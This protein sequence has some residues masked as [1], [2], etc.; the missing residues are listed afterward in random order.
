MSTNAIKPLPV[1]AHRLPPLPYAYDALMP[2]ISKELLT[3][4]HDKHHQ[5]YVDGLNRAEKR[6]A[7][8]RETGDYALVKHWER[9]IAFHGSGHILHSIFWTIMAPPGDRK[10]LALT[11]ELINACFGSFARFRDQFTVA[12]TD[13]EASGWAILGYQPAFSRLEIY[14]AEKHQNLTQW[15]AIPILVLDVWEHA[16][17]LD[18]LN[19]RRDWVEAWWK[20]VNW[21]E[22]ESRLKLA[23]VA[24]MPLT[25]E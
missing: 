4:H 1:G 3:L 14:T 16:Y 8:A 21:E 15:G 17:Y 2:V 19:K 7:E 12:A 24:Q 9:E 6:L 23:M 25:I 18:Y 10:P 13:V 20:L 11:A 22:V 5:A